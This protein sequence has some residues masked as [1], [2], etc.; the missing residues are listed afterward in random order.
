M[1]GHNHPFNKSW[2]ALVFLVWT[3]GLLS[4]FWILDPTENIF[5][6]HS[7]ALANP[8][9]AVGFPG[10]FNSLGGFLLGSLMV[11]SWLGFGTQ[12]LR[13]LP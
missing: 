8:V 6:Q 7:P 3:M 2:P 13:L 10:L 11:V 5:I 9:P 4:F 1:E 12:L